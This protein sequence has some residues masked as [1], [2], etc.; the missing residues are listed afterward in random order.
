MK[1]KL[2][3]LFYLL[4]FTI[5]S[6][7]V[8]DFNNSRSKVDIYE[9]L[10]YTDDK[11]QS[12]LFDMFLPK[13]VKNFPVVVFVHGGYWNSQDKSYFRPFT[14]LYSNIG[15]KLAK[16]NIGALI[17][18]YRV[19]PETNIE[20]ELKD[21]ISSLDWTIKNIK[22]YNGDNNKVYLS[23]HSAGGHMALLIGLNDDISIKNNFSN[24]NIK[25][26]IAMSPIMDLTLTQGRYPWILEAGI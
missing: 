19:Y 22:K 7:A 23:G 20:G 13:D 18:N 3:S 26:I 4:S 2:F 6:C 25:G 15:L 9:N 11:S 14:G 10:S 24:K 5:N 21:I 16:N 17:I 1:T 8:L 12:H